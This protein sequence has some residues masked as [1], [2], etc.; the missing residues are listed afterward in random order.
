MKHLKMFHQPLEQ[1][2]HQAQKSQQLVIQLQVITNTIGISVTFEE[3]GCIFQE[4]SFKGK[5]IFTMFLLIF[6]IIHRYENISIF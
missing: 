4:M 6:Q 5:K 1:Q 3:R 2:L